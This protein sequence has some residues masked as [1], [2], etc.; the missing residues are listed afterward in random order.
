[1]IFPNQDRFDSLMV[2]LPCFLLVFSAVEDIC[3]LGP[4]FPYAYN[5]PS[6]ALMCSLLLLKISCS[7]AWL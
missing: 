7:I 6:L 3:M 4:D 2:C 1:M 5:F